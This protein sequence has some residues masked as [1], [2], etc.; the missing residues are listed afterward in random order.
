MSKRIAHV[1]GGSFLL[2]FV[3]MHIGNHLWGVVF[4]PVAHEAARQ[5]LRKVYAA[6]FVEPILALAIAAQCI[7]G[8]LLALRAGV[9]RAQGIRRT[10][11]WAGLVLVG[12][13]T[14]H[15]ST[16]GV[17]RLSGVTTDIGFASAGVQ[18]GVWALF[19]VPYYALAVIALFVHLHIGF[20]RLSGRRPQLWHGV[21]V[22]VVAAGAILALMTG[23][24]HT[25]QAPPFSLPGFTIR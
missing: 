1:I 9:W 17:A 20:S 24:V 10:Q 21:T 6:P 19:F 16:V 18:D 14:V 11:I 15:V 2:I 12:F 5:A 13:L 25:L 4:G 7:S 3:I 23:A 8:V 22:G